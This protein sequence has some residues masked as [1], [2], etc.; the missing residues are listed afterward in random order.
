MG[1][2]STAQV[3]GTNMTSDRACGLN[4]LKKTAAALMAIPGFVVCLFV[5]VWALS[6]FIGEL[7]E[8]KKLHERNPL[9]KAR[10]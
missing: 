5:W 6:S 7:K 3:L 2:M 1:C 9:V 10:S 8:E 4:W